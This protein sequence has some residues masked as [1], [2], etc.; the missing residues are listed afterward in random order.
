MSTVNVTLHF[1]FTPFDVGAHDAYSFVFQVSW[2]AMN[3]KNATS[4]MSGNISVDYLSFF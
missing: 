3:S 2:V 4:N 1:L